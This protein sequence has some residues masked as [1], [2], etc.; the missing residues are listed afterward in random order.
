VGGGHL[1][2][3]TGGLGTQLPLD[4]VAEV[5]KAFLLGGSHEDRTGQGNDVQH[6]LNLVSNGRG[7][8]LNHLLDPQAHQALVT[9]EQSNIESRRSSKQKQEHC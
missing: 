4:V 8:L 3:A 7:W 6:V 2:Q 9:S 1:L 5:F